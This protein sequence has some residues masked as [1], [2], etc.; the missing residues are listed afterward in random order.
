MSEQLEQQYT[1][2]LAES[3][4]RGEVMDNPEG[5]ERRRHPRIR[6]NSGD[7]PVEIDPWVF[8][9]DVSL[10]GMAFYAD[11]P[12]EPG[13]S[14]TIALGDHYAVEASVVDCHPEQSDSSDLPSRH[15]MHCRFAE[16]ERGK[17]LLVM[18]KDLENEPAT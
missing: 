15:R 17:Q 4:T 2:V 1:R 7:L 6:V 9:I 10:S 11:E 18:I 14:V 12:V 16:E 5:A 13:R 8:A 3:R